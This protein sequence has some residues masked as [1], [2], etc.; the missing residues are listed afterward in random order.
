MKMIFFILT[1]AFFVRADN[2]V[3]SSYGC[4]SP[5]GKQLAASTK[6]GEIV[7]T[8][9]QGKEIANIDSTTGK[10]TSI[11]GGLRISF[12]HEEGDTVL[13]IDEKNTS[14]VATFRGEQFSCKRK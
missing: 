10:V 9:K 2:R 4:V 12:V 5:S 3:A 8:N 6:Y 1:A 11:S 7:V 14:I 13:V